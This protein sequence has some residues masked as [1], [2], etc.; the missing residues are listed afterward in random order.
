VM[1]REIMQ[2]DELAA[3][4]ARD[5]LRPLQFLAVG[6]RHRH[7]PIA[8]H[9]YCF[10]FGSTCHYHSN[11]GA[12]VLARAFRDKSQARSNPAQ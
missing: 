11:V 10:I 2:V 4:A 7:A 9:E 6:A 1:Q 5:I 3:I 12:G 8:T